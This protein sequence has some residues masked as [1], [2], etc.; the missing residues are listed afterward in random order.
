V[1]PD[2]IKA[3]ALATLSHRVIVSPAARV[4]SISAENV[5][6]ECMNRVPVPGSRARGGYSA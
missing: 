2:D 3:L 5:V 4:K 1:I 6:E